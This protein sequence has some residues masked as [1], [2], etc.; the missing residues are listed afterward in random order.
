M[1]AA[2]P[3][4]ILV[5]DDDRNSRESLRRAL[6]RDGYSVATAEDGKAALALARSEPFDLVLTDLIMP[7]LGGMAFLDGLRV[8]CPD[9]PAILVSAFANV[10]TAVKAVQR[11]VSDV[12]EKPIRLRD[13]RKAVRRA[14]EGRLPA[15]RGTPAAGAVLDEPAA[16]AAPPVAGGPLPAAEAPSERQL[17]RRRLVGRSPAFLG[18]LDLVER[19][20]PTPSTVLLL[21]ESGTG[22]ELIAEA[23]HAASPRAGAPLVK[24]ACAALAE[25]V[26]EAELFGSERGAYTG[27]VALRRGRFELAHGGTIFLDEIGDLPL[28]LQVKL[29]RVLQEGEFERVG[30]EQTLHVDVRVLAA[31]HRDLEAEVRAGRFRED[32]YWR[33][34]VIP[35]QVPPLR[36]RGDD[37]VLLAEHVLR[38][39][40]GVQGRSEPH[41][42]TPE[43]A[44]LLAAYRWPGNVRELENAVERAVALARSPLVRP[45]DLPAT[46]QRAPEPALRPEPRPAP[47]PARAPEAQRPA[48]RFEVG[49]TLE[50]LEREAIRLTL[51]AVDGNR[52]AAASL[53]GISLATLY[54]R[55]KEMGEE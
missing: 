6:E 54:R 41:G 8:I 13:V 4:R 18:L 20:A 2:V 47:E 1:V 12:L 29:L 14:M 32:L 42:F 3:A 11:G 10:D 48:V 51:A 26:L 27:S 40:L 46:L 16:P 35:V 31:T 44:A 15:T 50:Q 53:L 55:L 34:N 21:G 5:V 49:Q 39:T 36:E 25:G 17:G 37:V 38:A 19:V 52:E 43:A 22:K 9:V 45:E 23:L 7:G 33:L 28:P 30:G 24:V